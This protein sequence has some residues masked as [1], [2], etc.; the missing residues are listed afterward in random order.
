M[1][2][3][4][5]SEEQVED[6][7]FYDLLDSALEDFNKTLEV[8]D[9][10]GVDTASKSVLSNKTEDTAS[11]DADNLWIDFINQV[12]NEFSDNL[13]QN[14]SEAELG[15]SFQK[16]T[17]M[18][19]NANAGGETADSEPIRADF[20]S[21]ITQALK[22]L[23]VTA[24][25]LQCQPDLAYM[26]GK[27][28]LE[29]G[30]GDILP[31]MQGMMQ[32]LLSKEILYPS[33]KELVDKYPEWLEQKKATL[34]SADLQ[35]YT[36]QLELMQ[37]ICNEL[38]KEQDTDTDEAKR[39]RFEVILSLMQDMQTYG[40]PPEELIGEHP[41]LFQFDSEGNPIIQTLPPGVET[42]QDCCIM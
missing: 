16:M 31:F 35:R 24:E 2:D 26:F 30:A 36:K 39:R 11:K 41:A 1:S 18:V 12:S 42:P 9:D 14:A 17:Q 20:Q 27:M 29:E 10:D 23:S 13:I 34:P 22:D 5:K 15:A 4:K 21:S 40:H 37:K 28:N 25:N 7:E 3:D 19:V 32:S 6:S 8:K 38:E 33:L